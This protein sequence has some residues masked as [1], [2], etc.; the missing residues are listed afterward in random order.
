MSV[1][2][3]MPSE[4]DVALS[5][6]SSRILTAYLQKNVRLKIVDEDGTEEPITIPKE[7]IHLLA[8]ILKEMAKG[9]TVSL[10]PNHA[11]LSTQQAADLLNVSRP[12]FVN[13]LE[14]GEIPHRK[15]GRHRRVRFTDVMDYKDRLD[16]AR[17][18]VLDEL[19]AQAQGLGMG[20]D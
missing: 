14:S 12:F 18:E 20:Y 11:E 13:L 3:P 6:Q 1:G 15:V 9:N 19:V 2:R 10:I 17:G 16:A 7:A 8:D 4:T 5:K